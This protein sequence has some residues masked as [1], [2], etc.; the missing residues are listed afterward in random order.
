[1]KDISVALLKEIINKIGLSSKSYI[2]INKRGFDTNDYIKQIWTA[3][4]NKSKAREELIKYSDIFNDSG[5]VLNLLEEKNVIIRLEL[6]EGDYKDFHCFLLP[7]GIELL[8][9]LDGFDLEDINHDQLDNLI[10]KAT[11]QTYEALITETI[12]RIQL[13]LLGNNGMSA[14]SSVFCWFLLLNGCISVDKAFIVQK[15]EKG[16]EIEFQDSIVQYLDQLSNRL[17]P[18][19]YSK[20]RS[21]KNFPI[22]DLDNFFRRSKD[23]KTTFGDNFKSDNEYYLNVINN[24]GEINLSNLRRIIST[25]LRSL[26]HHSAEEDNT[27][28]AVIKTVN[29]YLIDCPIKQAHQS[30]L[31]AGRPIFDYYSTLEYIVKDEIALMNEEIEES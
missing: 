29:W 31:F 10:A 6:E 5:D 26:N 2:N 27:F 16:G 15:K 28:E 19:S 14:K 22:G 24:D 3:R 18:S 8:E 17:F 7:L 21:G 12:N 25:V 11:E 9:I 23:I 30:I 1:L 13:P 20:T 4:Y